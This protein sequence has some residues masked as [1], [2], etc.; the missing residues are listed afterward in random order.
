[1][2]LRSRFLVMLLGL[3]GIASMWLAVF[4]DTGVAIVVRAQFD[5]HAVYEDRI[6]HTLCTFYIERLPSD[7][8]GESFY[9]YRLC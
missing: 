8:N 2:H 5:P 4:A 7:W 3:F 6:M 1:M 9:S